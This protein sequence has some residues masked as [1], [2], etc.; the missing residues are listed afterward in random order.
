M[1]IYGS[2]IE[3]GKTP[4]QALD[5]VKTVLGKTA[6]QPGSGR[7]ALAAFTQGEGDVLI[8]YENEA[9]KPPRARARTS[10]TSSPTTTS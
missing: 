4:A 10:T 5:A 8:S 3:E 9:I 1:A 7:D 2:Q 6:V